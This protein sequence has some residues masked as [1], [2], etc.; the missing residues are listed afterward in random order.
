MPPSEDPNQTTDPAGQ[1]EAPTP[2]EY[3]PNWKVIV[4]IV[5]ISAVVLLVCLPVCA[6]LIVNSTGC[7]LANGPEKIITFWA[8]MI[9]GFLALFGMLVT[10]V[11]VIT[12]LRVEATARAQA[13]SEAR[14][15]AHDVSQFV[16]E[17]TT[18]EFIQS[19]KGELFEALE[20]ASDEVAQR[21]TEV[22]GLKRNV[23]ELTG[24]VTK[25]QAE[26]TTLQNEATNARTAID[27]AR[28]QTTNLANEAQRV[29]GGERDRITA[30][31]SGAQDAIEG[32]RQEVMGQRDAAVGAI[33]SARE[34]VESAASEAQDRIGRA[35][36]S[37]QGGDESR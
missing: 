20:S 15:T 37:P 33:D 10:G 8:S 18:K 13:Q 23:E 12:S 24:D 25:L 5:L 26:V 28:Q 4:P 1:G 21:A 35:G 16:A 9:A 14:M 29:I 30:A 27:G 6:L 17:Q 7:C 22:A 3:K 31:A 36:D 19:R 2:P 32:A 11:F 34:A